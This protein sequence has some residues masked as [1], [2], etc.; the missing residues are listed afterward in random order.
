MSRRPQSRAARILGLCWI[1]LAPL[2]ANAGA[3]APPLPDTRAFAA[4]VR[5]RLLG[6]RELQSQYTFLE[7]REEISVSKLGK[8]GK[9]P[10]KVYEVYP[11]VEPGNTYKRLISVDGAPL[12]AAELEKS[13][14]RHR[15]DVLRDLKKREQESPGARAKRARREAAER[16]E[17]QAVLDEIFALYD[18]RLVGRD[19]IA[20]HPTVVAT[21]D[22]KRGYRPRIDAGRFM[23][24]VRARAWVSESEY[25]VVKVEIEMIDDVTFGWGIAGR[26][27]KGSHGVF[28]RRKV[29]GEVWLP[30][31]ATFIGT[32]RALLF[33]RFSIDAVTTYSDYRKFDVKTDE[34]F[35]KTP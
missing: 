1:A 22:P 7:R 11:S 13:D 15:D 18:I 32:G 29:N 16:A 28:E 33:R 23:T 26:L 6:D 20:G 10:V 35:T 17:N 30:A 14:R 5:K 21:L 25:Q 8:V 24:K 27:H 9:G 2:A 31:R 19:T 34:H 12:A 3:Q 4:E